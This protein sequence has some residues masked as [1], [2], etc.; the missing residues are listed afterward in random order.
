MMDSTEVTLPIQL[1]FD[2]ARSEMI[3]RE[4]ACAF[5]D[6]GADVAEPVVLEDTGT[7]GIEPLVVTLL[8]V[9]AAKAL[10]GIALRRL[11][12]YLNARIAEDGD[13][14]D[15]TLKIRS[16]SGNL[17]HVGGIRIPDV[18]AEAIAAFLSEARQAIDDL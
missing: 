12:E 11:E 4:L 8:V 7:L 5:K 13:R 6:V 10:A 2:G 3:S 17:I 9:P 14:F 1:G 16:P 15:V 18:G